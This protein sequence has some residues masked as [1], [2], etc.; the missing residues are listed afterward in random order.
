MAL[1]AMTISCDTTPTYD[2]TVVDYADNFNSQASTLV[3]LTPAL[4]S[5]KATVNDTALSLEV[6]MDTTIVRPR[7]LTPDNVQRMLVQSIGNENA[8]PGLADALESA[9]MSL[10][11]TC[12]GNG[13]PLVQVAL[14]PAQLRRAQHT[15]NNK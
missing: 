9:G 1:T 8:E 14:S 10:Q 4:N 3:P 15:D 6:D 13:T 5:F 7:E 11:Y 2:P 12:T